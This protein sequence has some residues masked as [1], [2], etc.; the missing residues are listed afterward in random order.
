MSASEGVKCFLQLSADFLSSAD[1]GARV[2]CGIAAA[3]RRPKIVSVSCANNS[4]ETNPA[5]VSDALVT[6]S[7]HGGAIAA[8]PAGRRSLVSL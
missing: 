6:P 2:A 4:I 7:F 5:A 8:H 1:S 3:I